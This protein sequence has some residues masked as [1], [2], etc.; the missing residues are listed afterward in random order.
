MD[1]I[2]GKAREKLSLMVFTEEYRPTILI[3]NFHLTS[4]L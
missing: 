3:K 4:M 2:L 1:E